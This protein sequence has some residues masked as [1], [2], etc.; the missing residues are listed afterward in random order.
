MKNYFQFSDWEKEIEKEGY[1]FLP[2]DK[3]GGDNF[4][5]SKFISSFEKVYTQPNGETTYAVKPR[6]RGIG[7]YHSQSMEGLLPHTECYEYPNTPPRYLILWCIVPP[8]EGGETTLADGFRFFYSLKKQVQEKL[9]KEKV[10]FHHYSGK[11][12]D[13]IKHP[14]FESNIKGRIFRFSCKGMDSSND[15]LLQS[16]IENCISFFEKEKYLVRWKTCGDM[17]II[18]NYRMLHARNAF[19]DPNREIMRAWVDKD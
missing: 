17:L 2:V 10:I 9:Q 11:G 6:K 13:F 1:I 7:E 19:T 14:I 15:P 18:D 12:N 4:S 16:L 3:L 5:H 8:K